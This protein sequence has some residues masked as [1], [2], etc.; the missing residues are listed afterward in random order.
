MKLSWCDFHKFYV[1]SSLS[2]CSAMTLVQS[3]IIVSTAE[4][5]TINYNLEACGGV[6]GI[7][8]Y[9]ILIISFEKQNKILFKENIQ[10]L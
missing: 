10:L 6:K 7:S 2:L 4:F 3:G 8:S 9:I 1:C 5:L